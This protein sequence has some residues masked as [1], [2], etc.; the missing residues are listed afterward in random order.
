VASVAMNGCSR[1][2]TINSPFNAP[3]SVAASNASASAAH[4]G[5]CRISEASNATM[6]ASAT[7]A[8]TDRSMPRSRIGSTCPI[9]TMATNE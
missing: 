3:A 7:I 1:R 8:P 2:P 6:P 9:A 5:R 4:P